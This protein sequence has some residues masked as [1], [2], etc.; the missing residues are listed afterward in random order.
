[1]YPTAPPGRH[2]CSPTRQPSTHAPSSHPL[3]GPPC[4]ACSRPTP[5]IHV[6]TLSCMQPFAHSAPSA[7]RG[8][9]EG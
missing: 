2:A 9:V 4:H 6:R 1:M 7:E 8:L 3:T 5:G